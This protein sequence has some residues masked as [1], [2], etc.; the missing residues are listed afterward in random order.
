MGRRHHR[1]RQ[2]AALQ[3]LWGGAVRRGR[4]LVTMVTK[5]TRTPTVLYDMSSNSDINVKMALDFNAHQSDY[6]DVARVAAP[7]L[8]HLNGAICQCTTYYN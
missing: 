2:K 8:A 6:V 1:Q 7:S 5:Y 4:E 3:D